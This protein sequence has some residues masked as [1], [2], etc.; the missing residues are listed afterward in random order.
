MAK[1]KT[2]M[3]GYVNMENNIL[4]FMARDDWRRHD[5]EGFNQ[6][7]QKEMTVKVKEHTAELNQQKKHNK[8]F[9][10]IAVQLKQV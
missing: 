8:P 9:K 10:I 5:W 4:G 6:P 7:K 1:Q 3:D 2:I